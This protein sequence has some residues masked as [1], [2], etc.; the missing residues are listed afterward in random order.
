M[1]PSLAT[2]RSNG[3]DLTGMQYGSLTV[4]GYAGGI[5]RRWRCLCSCGSYRDARGQ[6]LRSGWA[7]SCG[8]NRRK[9]IVAD[10]GAYTCT[11]CHRELPADS[12]LMRKARAGTMRIAHPCR[13][14]LAVRRRAKGP[15]EVDRNHHR[16]FV[17]SRRELMHAL[18]AKPCRDCGRTFPPECMDFDHVRGTKRHGVGR[19][20]LQ[21]MDFLMKEIAKCDLVCS[22]C[23]RIRTSM[24]RAAMGADLQGAVMS[25]AESREFLRS[26]TYP[27]VQLETPFV[28]DRGSIQNITTSGAKSVALITSRAGSSRASHVH[29]TD[30]HLAWVASGRV[31]YW[32]QDVVVDG[33]QIAERLGEIKSVIVEAGQAFYTPRHVAHTMHFPVDTVFLTISCQS[34]KHAD[35]E[36]DLIRVPSLKALAP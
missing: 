27:I 11:T 29:K 34:R 26:P 22:N 30:D 35:H 10:D 13:E 25:L 21:R 15:S 12:F 16:A 33:D 20:K 23:H 7:T 24:R 6:E 28:D 17:I 3:I 4:V 18:K 1:A 14:C 36:A 2:I 9:N 32:W 8:C 5:Y 31:E 19:M